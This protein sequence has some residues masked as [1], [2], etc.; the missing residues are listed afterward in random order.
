MKALTFFQSLLPNFSS[1]RI[2]S[3][4]ARN[5]EYINDTLIKNLTQAQHTLAGRRLTS[6]AAMEFIGAVRHILPMA[7]RQG[8]FL[9]LE[10]FFKNVLKT[11]DMLEEY[12]E[13]LFDGEITKETMTYQEMA[14][15]KYLENVDFAAKYSSSLLNRLLT[16]ESAAV[17]QK[18]EQSSLQRW[19]T[20][21]EERWLYDNQIR[22]IDV[23]KSL[24][25]PAD[26]TLELIKTIPQ[27][28]VDKSSDM[29]NQ[30]SEMA[31]INPLRM[32]FLAPSISPVFFLRRV[33]AEWEHERYKADKEE[34]RYLQMK[35]IELKLALDGK[36]DASIEKALEYT[37][38]RLDKLNARI[39]DYEEEVN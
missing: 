19:L 32:N 11:L 23:L 10:L 24:N 30:P 34:A 16:A 3:T 1:S 21:Y 38:G 28:S 37:K 13:Q 17:L 25:V 15:L 8:P 22:F 27:A 14:I 7:S 26:K 31:K 4:I 2:F 9:A 29:M 36:E 20:R 33:F 39:K 18:D 12:A 35:I 6:P 5:R